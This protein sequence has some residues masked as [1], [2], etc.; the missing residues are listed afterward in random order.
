MSS[1]NEQKTSETNSSPIEKAIILDL[2]K[3]KR[4]DIKRLRKG[5]G[6]LL[7]RVE[8]HLDELRTAGAVSDSVQPIIVVVA[9]KRPKV[10]WL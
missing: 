7:D 8:D 10:G 2:G 4:K 3:K 5:R 9:E 1:A 6:K